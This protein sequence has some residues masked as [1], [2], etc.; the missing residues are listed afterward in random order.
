MTIFAAIAA[1]GCT[2]A[3]M[4][5]E[6]EAPAFED[7]QNATFSGI[8]EMD[9]AEPVTLSNGHWEG[10]PAV[11]GGASVPMADLIGNWVLSADLDDD[12]RMESFSLLNYSGGGTG[13]FVHL[14]VSR[15][16]NGKVSNFDT[17]L[18]GD[19]VQIVD[20]RI[21]GAEVVLQLVQAGPGDGACCPS[22]LV[23]RRWRLLEGKL[24]EQAAREAPAQL[25]L[26]LLEGRRWQLSRW[27]YDERVADEVRIDLEYS[28][29]RISG[30]S[31]C[32]RYFAS[33][34]AGELAA[35][36][37]VGPVGSTRRACINP[38]LAQTETRFLEALGKAT[39]FSFLVGELVISWGQNEEFGS[40]FFTA[41]EQE[42]P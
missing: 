18:L 2:G 36:I 9:G 20:M 35:S 38:E 14:A 1:I 41:A 3:L 15:F 33:A 11:P 42:S 34:G 23:T 37:T 10:E 17:R 8:L 32:N 29:G 5:A 26:E 13:Q 4:A 6:P 21:E 16:D 40:L 24:A 19:R 12:G 22:E 39:S 25:S 31:T 27:G 30:Q 28:G 7:L